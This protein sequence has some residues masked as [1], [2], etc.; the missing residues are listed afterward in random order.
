MIPVPT[1]AVRKEPEFISEEIQVLVPT[2]RQNKTEQR[3]STLPPK[4]QK[5]Q[6]WLFSTDCATIAGIQCTD[7][8]KI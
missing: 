8:S 3:K 5:Q 1:T 6:D 7:L 2:Q 4:H